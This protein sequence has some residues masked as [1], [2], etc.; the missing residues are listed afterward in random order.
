MKVWKSSD[1][2]SVGSSGVATRSKRIGLLFGV[3]TFF[4]VCLWIVICIAGLEI[5]LRWNYLYS[6]VKWDYRKGFP[7]I[8]IDPE[9][10]IEMGLKKNVNVTVKIT[11]KAIYRLR[12]N[13]L[14]VRDDEDFPLKKPK[15][16]FRV[17]ALGDSW[18]FG[19][20]VNIED[21]Y[22]KVIER[23]LKTR[24]D[25]KFVYRGI[26]CGYASGR[27]P[28]S[29]Y[30]F[31]RNKGIRL[32][33]DVVILG[34]FINDIFDISY[35]NWHD[36]DADGLP[37]RIDSDIFSVG[38]NGNYGYKYDSNSIEAR[39]RLKPPPFKFLE[40]SQVYTMMRVL[41][42]EKIFLKYVFPKEKLIRELNSEIFM[43]SW[44]KYFKVVGGMKALCERNGA[45]FIVVFL[46][47][48]TGKPNREALI[49]RYNKWETA[50]FEEMGVGLLDLNRTFFEL[51]PLGDVGARKKYFI[52]KD[53][54]WT[55][56][57]NRVG[58][59]LI[60]DELFR[61][62]WIPAAERPGVER[63]SSQ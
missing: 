37:A 30:V 35:N 47:Y 32:E 2:K 59:T 52:E 57:G 56:E 8:E 54:H 31:L 58:G 5:Y 14:R 1:K 16:E 12:T 61:R 15:G 19:E 44:D 9:V 50:K 27:G 39:Y 25:P 49:A 18:T 36:L 4:I 42:I 51:V 24:G 53:G 13:S 3:A 17:I 48:L 21:T 46:P 40:Y 33:P 43:V 26:N 7:V 41:Y 23:L 6:P 29:A 63:G 10:P 28:D 38:A 60:A 55:E 22:I 34:S 11:D 20:G 45:R 62:G